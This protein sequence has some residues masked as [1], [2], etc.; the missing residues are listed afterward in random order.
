[1]LKKEY[2]VIFFIMLLPLCN[3]LGFD[4]YSHVVAYS[5]F[6]EIPYIYKNYHFGDIYFA[7]YLL[8]S[9]ILELGGRIGFPLGILILFLI[10]IPVYSIFKPRS[11]FYALS[12]GKP[13]LN[14]IIYF[15]M[16]FMICLL[17]FFYSA[18]S[19]SILWCIA[20]YFNRNRVLIIGSVFH[21]LG[22]VIYMI[23]NGLKRLPVIFNLLLIFLGFHVGYFLL[24]SEFF[25]SLA[26]SN[27]SLNL[28]K[29]DFD[30]VYS[31]SKEIL[32]SI[33]FILLFGR[34][35]KMI[36]NKVSVHFDQVIKVRNIMLVT[37][38]TSF[39]F[40][41]FVT[42]DKDTPL[43]FLLSGDSNPVFRI[44]WFVP[45]REYSAYELTNFRYEK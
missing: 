13:L 15:V 30:V 9:I 1:M 21:P 42:I 8:L 44:A 2:I 41:F 12:T 19:L 20:Y 22:V 18:L 45:D 11:M 14:D 17:V 38:F 29:F 3:T 24:G 43:V 23:I 10:F 40:V 35:M 33:G 16:V 39:L 36:I 37:V 34:R 4:M 28:L 31:K 25:F 7:R 32:F 26:E 6:E 5:S 27:V